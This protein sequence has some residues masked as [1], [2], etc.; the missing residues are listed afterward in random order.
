MT[1]SL[2]YEFLGLEEAPQVQHL[3]SGQSQE[4]AH[5]EDAE[6]EHTAVGRLCKQ[7]DAHIFLV[8]NNYE[9]VFFL[10]Q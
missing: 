8:S 1:H 3:P 2:L 6:V 10:H 4:T 7:T 9:R 5:A